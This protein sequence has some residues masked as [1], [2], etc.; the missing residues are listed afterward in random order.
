MTIAILNDY[1]QTFGGGEKYSLELAKRYNAPIYTY[2]LIK[3]Y[4]DIEKL[5][6]NKC[7]K[8]IMI[9]P[10]R[11]FMLKNF[12]SSLNLKD[13]DIVFANG[14]HSVYASLQN[15]NIV[16]IN[17]HVS[18]AFYKD[19]SPVMPRLNPIKEVLIKLIIHPYRKQYEKAIKRLKKIF[20]ISNYHKNLLQKIFGVR[21]DVLYPFV[22]TTKF[23]YRKSEDYYL[24]VGRLVSN[25]RIDILVKAFKNLKDRLVIVGDG[26]EKKYLMKL[27]NGASNIEFLGAKTGKELYELY[28][29]CKAFLFSAYYEDFGLVPVEAMAAGKP[30][31]AVNEGAIPEIVTRDVG[32][33]VQPFP[34]DFRRVI[35]SLRGKDLSHMRKACQ[36]R[37]KLF[38]KKIYFEKIDNLLKQ[39]A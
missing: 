7:T 28:A 31:I 14:F 12:F 15:E 1:F 6:V 30:V 39:F 21:C 2:N 17:G 27:A 20:A 9:W 23:Y 13:Y 8:P 37:A 29:R 16:W 38:D 11:V 19:E 3:T 5:K 33:L 25:K 36:R 35:L 32:F 26:P 22:D 24:S 18:K 4:R 10:I 34:E